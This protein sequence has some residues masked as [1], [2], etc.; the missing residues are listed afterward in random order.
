MVL[1]QARLERELGVRVEEIEFD[2]NL[3]SECRVVA[4]C[5]TEN[6]IR[7]TIKL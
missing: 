1:A 6:H 4:Y 3:D 7:F 5:D 2:I